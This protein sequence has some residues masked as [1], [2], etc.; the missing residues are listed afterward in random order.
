VFES[1]TRFNPSSRIHS[2]QQ[3]GLSRS[4]ASSSIG[5]KHALE[6]DGHIRREEDS[7]LDVRF[8]YLPSVAPP[9]DFNEIEE[10]VSRLVQMHARQTH[11]GRLQPGLP[12]G[13]PRRGLLLCHGLRRGPRTSTSPPTLRCSRSSSACRRSITRCPWSSRRWRARWTCWGCRPCR[14][15]ASRRR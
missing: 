1:G 3:E 14:R 5:K 13:G 2:V 9:T 7:S 10:F 4:I 11:G 12:R 6:V 15:R 8:V